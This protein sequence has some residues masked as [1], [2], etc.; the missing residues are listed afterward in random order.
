[1]CVHVCIGRHSDVVQGRERAMNLD[2]NDCQNLLLFLFLECVLQICA[3][4]YLYFVDIQLNF[5][6][7]SVELPYTL[8][9][10][11]QEVQG[12]SR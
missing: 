6:I 8:Y 12:W 2:I 4:D 10:L 1:M 3:H 9:C 5:T 7:V 11:L